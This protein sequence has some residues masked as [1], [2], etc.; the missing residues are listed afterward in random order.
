MQWKRKIH[1]V[2]PVFLTICLFFTGQENVSATEKKTVQSGENVT[3]RLGEYLK[4]LIADDNWDELDRY[5]ISRE[6]AWKEAA[7]MADKSPAYANFAEYGDYF[8]NSREAIILEAD[9]NGD[10]VRDIMEYLPDVGNIQVSNSHLQQNILTIFD[11]KDASVIYYQP[12]FDTL[13]LHGDELLV[14]EYGEN[15]FFLFRRGNRIT[16]YRME[17]GRFV[18]R[19][20][21]EVEYQEAE[22]E[23]VDCREGFQKE[24]DELCSNAME[25]LEA[26]KTSGRYQGSA[27]TLLEED[28]DFYKELK[29]VSD[30]EVQECYRR[31]LESVGGYGA[32]PPSAIGHSA[33][34]L[35]CC[36]IDNDGEEEWYAK[37]K[38]KLCLSAHVGT[39]IH[40]FM[41]GE[42]YGNGRHEGKYGL[43]YT[44]VKEGAGT[45]IG[46][47]SGLDIWNGEDT[48]QMFW[49]E[50]KGK[51]NIT[52]IQYA[53]GR[54]GGGGRIVAYDI[55]DGAHEKV[56]E[57]CYRPVYTF[58]E[59]YETNRNPDN[60]LHYTVRMSVK[61]GTAEI[62]GME[63]PKIQDGINRE[64]KAFLWEKLMQVLY[65]GNGPVFQGFLDFNVISATED[66][67]ELYFVVLY[68]YEGV[69]RGYGENMILEIDLKD[70]NVR[71]AG[72]ERIGQKSGW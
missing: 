16:V 53:D 17:N 37:T 67:L 72:D 56:L 10:G 48:P 9:I 63:N 19:L 3:R 68:G 4:G 8:F 59:K 11:G 35:C 30:E 52:Y 13:V 12:W 51:E 41:T 58:R 20:M 15:L 70:G 60:G 46:E 62:Y 42:L 28:S 21:L 47:I 32:Y 24:A 18:D 57:V 61:K 7:G 69:E 65:P 2:M 38:S 22:T 71:L 29:R 27:E 36:D 40:D 66:K 26:G 31:F 55:R 45:N 25:Y 54:P 34:Y 39:G 64:I 43:I 44:M 1:K 50:K 33:A 14:M 49:V 6:V 23:I 5:V